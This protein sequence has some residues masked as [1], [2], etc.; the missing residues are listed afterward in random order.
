MNIKIDENLAAAHA[1][2]LERAGHDVHDV[3]QEGLTG[4]ADSVIW[5]QVCDEDRFFITLDTDFSDVRR[6]E[7]GTH[8]GIL[9]LRSSRP[10]VAVI[11]GILQRVLDET[12]LDTLAG[13]LAVADE[14]R[15]RIRAVRSDEEE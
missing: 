11:A 2:L 5:S 7:P 15:T 3:H 14:S 12:P 13:C 8:P 4:A 1:A 10:S 9:L 6:F